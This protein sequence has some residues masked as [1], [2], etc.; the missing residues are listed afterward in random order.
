MSWGYETETKQKKSR[1]SQSL[2]INK[3]YELA[4]TPC[5]GSFCSTKMVIIYNFMWFSLNNMSDG[6]K[7]HGE[8]QSW[9]KG[10]SKY[11]WDITLLNRVVGEGRNLK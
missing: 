11:M 9:G 2:Q 10:E 6:D 7:W 5:T 1:L 3:K 4:W 8:Q